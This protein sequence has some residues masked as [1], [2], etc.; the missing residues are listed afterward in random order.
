MPVVF[1]KGRQPSIGCSDIH[2][3][4]SQERDYRTHNSAFADLLEKQSEGRK[5][6]KWLDLYKKADSHRFGWVN[7]FNVEPDKVE[8]DKAFDLFLQAANTGSARA[9]CSLGEMCLYSEGNIARPEAA[10][11]Y[12]VQ[13]A[14]LGDYR[15]RLFIAYALL[16]KGE[17]AKS[18]SEIKLFLKELEQDI[19]Y[20]DGGASGCHNAYIYECL[21]RVVLNDSIL[22]EDK[23]KLFFDFEEY[24]PR[25]EHE[26][27]SSIED[28]YSP[29]S[30]G[31][32]AAKGVLKIIEL[33]RGTPSNLAS[34]F[35]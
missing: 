16:E 7:G 11:G 26:A 9:F 2:Q 18:R 22:S 21:R 4:T 8:P 27:H 29:E 3:T 33:L 25:I 17:L 5:K 6:H 34:H 31:A 20:E 35:R 30:W 14:K 23:T 13:G 19:G 32:I 12:F 28:A 10:I 1:S 15:C 24:W